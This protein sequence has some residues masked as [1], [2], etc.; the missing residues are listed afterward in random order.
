MNI[1]RKLFSMLLLILGAVV[2]LSAQSPVT[3][4]NQ[5]TSESNLS[6]GV[7]YIIYQPR[8]S[9]Y[10]KEASDRYSAFQGNSPDD[11]GVFYFI[12][13]SD[14]VYKIK[15]LSTG[16]FISKPTTTGIAAIAPVEEASAG[17]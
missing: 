2:Q 7:P 16:K 11:N 5:V 15:S 9:T 12:K 14:G 13:V 17:E 4:G 10:V 6:E 3:R 1:K 8:N